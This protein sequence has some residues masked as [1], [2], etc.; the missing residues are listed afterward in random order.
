MGA[1]DE[2]HAPSAL[3]GIACIDASNCFAD[4][5]IGTVVATTDGGTTWAQQ[6][7]PISGPTTALNA[8]EHRA[9]TAAACTAARCMIGLGVAGRHHDHAARS[10]SR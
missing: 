2:R 4:G 8:D 9:S 6:G 1:A 10:R 5:A 3:S 7:N